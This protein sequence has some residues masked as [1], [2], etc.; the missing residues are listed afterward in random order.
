M[1]Q[2]VVSGFS[3][4][5][6]CFS[7]TVIAL[8]LFAAPAYAQEAPPGDGSTPLHW[9]AH[10][11]ELAK[12]DQLIRAGANVNAANDI[13]ATPLWAASVHGSAAIVK[14]LLDAG[15]NPNAALV[16]GETPLMA[17]SRAGRTDAV[18]ALL[19]KGANPNARGARGQ[20]ALM[21]AVAQKHVDVV[22]ALLVGG[23]DVHA[24]TD[25]W[26]Q[27][28]AVP[29]HGLPEYNRLIPHGADTA[30]MF[31]ARA[32]DLASV[33]LLIEAGANAS[34]HD[35]WGVSATSLA[36][37]S[38][39]GE[40]AR[41]LLDK[42]ADPN[43]ATPGFTALH[44]A[45]M[46]RDEPTVAALL[47]RGADPN[48]AVKM[49]TPT[50]RSSDDYHFM[51]ALVGATPYWLAARFTQPAVMRLLAKHGADPKVIHESSYAQ[52][53]GYQR[54]KE[55]T[56]AIMAALGMGGGTAWLPVDRGARDALV[57][58]TVRVA[59]ELGA[60]VNA[61]T[62]DGRTALDSARA[63]KYDAVAAF[64]TERGAVASR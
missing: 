20:T 28:M 40:I 24:R 31:A 19:A 1:T 5:V 56:T 47:A 35:A 55:R 63:Q 46:R 17:A 9:A 30:L 4:T 64:L 45:V 51:P 36:T 54:R 15:A 49:W 25:T 16:S 32:G 48:A 58:E 42:G 38:G 12:V 62:V 29:P 14:R 41:Y 60:D 2:Y 50:R 18:Q 57:L 11:D 33:K 7:R 59:V 23:A 26:T 44:V 27:M 52:G 53:E 8:L 13:G 34:D 43:D 21:W 6:I 61:A 39:H 22:K 10:R 37:F 3:R